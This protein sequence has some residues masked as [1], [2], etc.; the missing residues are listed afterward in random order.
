[1][2][3]NIIILER[4]LFSALGH[5]RT[6][7]NAINQLIGNDKAS[8]ISCEDIN[9]NEMP[10]KNKII[11]Q[12]PKLNL[13]EE[14]KEPKSYIQESGKKLIKIFKDN[15]LNKINK[16][17]IPSARKL[18]ISLITYLYKIN[19]FPQ[20]ITPVI[21]ILDIVFIENLPKTTLELFFYLV[22][23]GKIHL[24]TETKELTKKIKN[25]IKIKCLGEFILPISVPYNL[26]VNPK[27]IKNKHIYIGCLGSPRRSKGTYQVPKIIKYL[28]Q[29]FKK[30]QINLKVTFIVQLSKDKT[31]RT[32]IF[33]IY[34]Y[35]SRY[36][37]GYVKIKYVYGVEDNKKFLKL[38][39]SI[40]IFLL[41]YSNIKYKYSGSGFITDAIFLE[42]PII[43]SKGMS[44]KDLTSFK[45]SES[46]NHIEDYPKA[47]LKIIKNYDYYSINSKLA[48]EYLKNKIKKSFNVI[49]N[50]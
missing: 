17:I 48:K 19:K 35:L 26:E 11:S 16:I 7:I 45:N 49:L 42:K 3:K 4:R 2:D 23:K 43:N 32:I 25:D 14:G 5:E 39:K 6:Q 10:F 30:N 15:K 50:K 20:S 22:N 29:Y 46:V 40:D 41:P 47:I 37:S 21:R 8:V 31:K 1:M 33:K 34:E 24:F 18:E 27:K 28:R 13:K 9:S 38:M 44:M 36:I 12:L